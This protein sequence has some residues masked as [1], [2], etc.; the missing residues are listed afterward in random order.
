LQFWSFQSLHEIGN[1]IG[2]F[3]FQ[4]EERE[5]RQTTTFTQICVD[6]DS[7]KGF[8]QNFGW[9]QKILYGPSIWTMRKQPLD[10][11]HLSAQGMLSVSAPWS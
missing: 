10:V 11:N 8:Q 3:H 5:N 6:M 4:T 9:S 2:K 1:D 7:Q